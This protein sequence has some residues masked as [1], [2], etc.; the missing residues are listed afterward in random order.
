MDISF[1]AAAMIALLI[2]FGCIAASTYGLFRTDVTVNS[3]GSSDLSNYYNQ[4]QIDALFIDYYNKTETY[5]KSEVATY[6]LTY[7]NVSHLTSELANYYNVS[8]V[9][10]QLGSY[11][12]KT[13]VDLL[14]AGN[15]S[16][17]YTKLEIDAIDF[18][19]YANHTDIPT[20]S[21]T[22][23]ANHS[24]INIRVDI[25]LSAYYAT[26]TANT[27]FSVGQTYINFSDFGH[28]RKAYIECGGKVNTTSGVYGNFA[29]YD[30]TTSTEVTGSN[31][32]FTATATVLR[33]GD[34]SANLPSG[35][36]IYG[37][38]ITCSSSGVMVYTYSARL[39]LFVSVV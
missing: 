35:E 29:L 27:T 4:T 20:Y 28:I 16:D 38:R 5:S 9:N 23:F 39:V 26:I 34:I 13:E 6:L 7:V 24:D 32:A 37:L 14:L 31:V 18:T 17:Y 2:L 12:N 1:T 30:V 11:Y 25:P 22:D 8:Q 10:N 15:L 21:F 19:G 3:T 36:D 33:S